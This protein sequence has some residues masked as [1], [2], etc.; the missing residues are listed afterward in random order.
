MRFVISSFGVVIYERGDDCVTS[1]CL[2]PTVK[3][4]LGLL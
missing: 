4:A 1:L 3:N 2:D